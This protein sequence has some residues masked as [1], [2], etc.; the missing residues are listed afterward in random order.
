MQV[1]SDCVR[2]FQ[3]NIKLCKVEEKLNSLSPRSYLYPENNPSS[4]APLENPTFETRIWK[5]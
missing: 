1:S 2:A 5:P 3:E 4:V